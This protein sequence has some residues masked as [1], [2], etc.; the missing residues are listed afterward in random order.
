MNKLKVEAGVEKE[1]TGQQIETTKNVLLPKLDKY[2]IYNYMQSNNNNCC[3]T[4]TEGERNES[5]AEIKE[6]KYNYTHTCSSQSSEL[7][8]S[9][10][11][12]RH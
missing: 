1:N 5:G 11:S 12:T 2:F 7:E 8:N 3:I 4:K 9:L 6:K 10:Q